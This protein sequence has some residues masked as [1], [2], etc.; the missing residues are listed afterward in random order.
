MTTP[1]AILSTNGLMN[2]NGVSSSMPKKAPDVVLIGLFCSEIRMQLAVLNPALLR[3]EAEG[4]QQETLAALMRAAHSLKGAAR[5]VHID[6]VVILAHEMEN[7]FVAVQ[8][9]K[10]VPQSVHCDSLFQSLD[11]LSA[12]ATRLE[13]FPTDSLTEETPAIQ[14]CT[15][16]IADLLCASERSTSTVLPTVLPILTT[17]VL[18]EVSPEVSP[19]VLSALPPAIS[20]TLPPIP[21]L[22]PSAQPNPIELNP[23]PPRT[24]RLSREN[25]SR[26]MGL[27]GESMTESTWLDPFAR[28]L[29]HVKSQQSTLIDLLDQLQAKLPQSLDPK[30]QSLL[31]DARTTASQCRRDLSDCTT[32]LDD[33]SR[34]STQLADR[35]YQEVIHSQMRPFSDI[36][37]AFPRMVRDLARQVDKSIKLDITG[38]S[39]PIDRDILDRLE[40]PLT[41]LLNNAIDHGIESSHDRTAVGKPAYGTLQLH[42]RHRAGTLVISV[43]DDGRGI[44]STTLRQQILDR[45]LATPELVAR[46]SEPELLEFL[47]L[48]G[49][50][51]APEVTALSGRGVGLDIVQNL[52]QSVGGSL[53]TST[54]V[55]MGTTFSLH[56]PLT[57]SVLRTLVVDIAGHPYAFPMTRIDRVL[58]L[59]ATDIQFAENRPYFRLE[60]QAIG[61]LRAHQVLSLPESPP[62]AK[63]SVL[64]LGDRDAHYGLVV[65]R[66]WGE[67]KLVVKPIDLRLGK[68]PNLSSTALRS[69]GSI[70]FI[71][72][73][74]DLL[75]SMQKLQAQTPWQTASSA[76]IAAAD[77]RN[78]ERSIEQPRRRILVIDDSI[79][80]RETERKLLENQGYHVDTAVNGADGWN[81]LQLNRYDLVI[82]DIDMPRMN[83]IELVSQ[84]KQHHTL[85]TIPT[86]IISYKDREDDRLKGLEVGANYYLTK[87]S[88]QDDTLIQAVMDLIGPPNNG[89]RSK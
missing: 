64:I 89:T 38:N 63:L 13:H 9:A 46:L 60:D 76:N 86:I 84:I 79:T 52:V 20:P 3:L 81:T 10:L 5:M 59:N 31:T 88:F 26:L 21:T 50:S 28:S 39:T 73:S 74:E 67:E 7:Y 36:S 69:D 85:Q 75:Q 47:Y 18:P 58:T 1:K 42:A 35:L 27:A 11:A 78:G 66:I 41:H 68:I 70:V 53:K 61:L 33:F 6:L 17:E 25:L 62:A 71:L 40:A 15:H 19:E 4:P 56:L 32:H 8:Q 54:Q 80:V 16:A 23:P 83:G 48:P 24:I 77:G 72:D 49:F 65:D 30:L 14:R 51:T 2:A 44:D 12:I 82:T 87:S 37:N 43:Q 55:G 22:I 45:N 57:L 29:L 34:R